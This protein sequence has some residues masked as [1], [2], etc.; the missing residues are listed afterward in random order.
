ML[1]P[2]LLA[3][4]LAADAG[5][6]LYEQRR[7]QEAAAAFRSALAAH[8]N[9]SSTRLYLAR[10]LMELDQLAEGLSE[11]QTALSRDPSP[12]IEFQAGKIIR[13]LAERRF[14]DLQRLAPDSAAVHEF[15]ARRYELQGKHADALREYR[16]AIAKEPARPG[17]HYMAGS[18]LWQMRELDE[19]EKELQAELA[20]SPHHGAANLRM[21]QLV[22]ARN[23]AGGAL[24]YLE[25]AATA[26]PDSAETRREL[27]K[28]LRD[29][30][31]MAEAKSQWEA[32]AAMRPDDDQ[33]HY[34]LG[35]L[36]RQ[37]GDEVRARRELARHRELLERRRKRD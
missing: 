24:P 13:Q 10:T 1:L 17:L 6:R 34:L 30:G 11:I 22:L 12:E 14:A 37:T 16:L 15:A 36:Y 31:R 29:S 2:A 5:I 23:Q 4:L 35:N 19:A 7:F 21:G 32:L 20:R 28:A 25:R 33:V 8:P 27:G 26:M 9:D 18:V 3:C